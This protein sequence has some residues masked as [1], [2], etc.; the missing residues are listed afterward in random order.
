MN[1]ESSDE[2]VLQLFPDKDEVMDGQIDHKNFNS[3][4]LFLKYFSKNQVLIEK[5]MNEI[6]KL[7]VDNLVEIKGFYFK[8]LFSVL[9]EVHLTDSVKNWIF[10]LIEVRSN[11]RTLSE[12]AKMNYLNSVFGKFS[13]VLNSE[14]IYLNVIPNISEH[15]V[16]CR[17][18][19]FPHGMCNG[20]IINIT[21]KKNIRDNADQFITSV[22]TKKD[23][24]IYFSKI[25]GVRLEFS[26]TD[27]SARFL[28][29]TKDVNNNLLKSLHAAFGAL[30][31]CVSTLHFVPINQKDKLATI[32]GSAPNDKKFWSEL[33]EIDIVL[34]SES[35]QA[36]A[37]Q[38]NSSMKNIKN[39]TLPSKN[40][41]D[42]VPLSAAKSS[43]IFDRLGPNLV[44]HRSFKSQ[45]KRL[46]RISSQASRSAN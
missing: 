40:Y 46:K 20:N 41:I 5:Q 19:Y 14:I 42:S 36:M 22:L 31:F 18:S 15:L 33:S 4:S 17:T 39:T 21:A 9:I 12:K 11:I 16:D 32:I 35:E 27:S 43:S 26:A 25:F 10:G 45:T 1:S 34:C 24:D 23:N 44:I 6:H 7:L 3:E 29:K 37:M 2:D 38:R 8:D 30:T 28:I 13:L